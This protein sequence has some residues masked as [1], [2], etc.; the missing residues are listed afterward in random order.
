[1][2]SNAGPLGQC[3]RDCISKNGFPVGFWYNINRFTC[4]I[5]LK[6]AA[7]ACYEYDS[8]IYF[9]DNIFHSVDPRAA[10]AEF[11]VAKNQVRKLLL[12]QGYSFGACSGNSHDV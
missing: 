5:A 8:S 9:A 2:V 10:I 1:M 4:E 12:G 6:Q 3:I 7:G 11:D